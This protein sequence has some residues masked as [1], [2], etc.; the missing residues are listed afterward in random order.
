[1][2]KL[3]AITGGIGAG[4]SVVSKILIT[5]GWPVFDCDAQAK[6]IMANSPEI[7][8]LIHDEV[9]PEAIVNGNIDRKVLSR[10]VFSDKESLKRLNSI[11]HSLVVKELTGWAK[12]KEISFVETAI[13][14]ESGIDRIVDEV[15]KVTAPEE[16]RIERVIKRSNM[17][18]AQVISRIESQ[19]TEL[20]RSHNVVR[21]IIN[22]G[23]SSLLFQIHEL[24]KELS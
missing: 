6:E 5:S 11:V 15:W 16:L 23:A 19:K 13:L 21:Q 8:K 7:K 3:I 24:L 20:L 4:K 22:D 17:T 1:M 12:G 18:R 10:K 2:G 14:Y 9:C